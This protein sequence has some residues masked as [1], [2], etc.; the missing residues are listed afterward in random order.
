[1][2]SCRQTSIW[3][4][5]NRQ[6]SIIAMSRRALTLATLLLVTGCAIHDTVVPVSRSISARAAMGA[7]R[8]YQHFISPHLRGVVQ[9]RFK[10][11]CSEYGYQSI[12][13]LGAVRGGWRAVVRIAR[14][15]PW[16]KAGTVDPP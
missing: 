16:T 1:M 15:G 10:P 7:I 3:S 12:R 9:C 4:I 13:K 5:V 11:T 8:Q 6:S 2:S 14:C